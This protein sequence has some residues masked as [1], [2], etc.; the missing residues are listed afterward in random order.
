MPEL[1]LIESTSNVEIAAKLLTDGLTR[2]LDLLAPIKTIQV[3]EKYA[4]FQK[5]HNSAQAEAA[6][7]GNQQDWRVYRSLR[8]QCLK[9]LQILTVNQTNLFLVL[10][11]LTTDYCQRFWPS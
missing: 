7:S 10:L 2:I 8:N 11:M 9:S 1:E 6:A 5:R 3:R 4:P